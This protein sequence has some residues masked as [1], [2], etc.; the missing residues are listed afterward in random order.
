MAPERSP[1]HWGRRVQTH[2]WVKPQR[3]LV[4]HFC[5]PHFPHAPQRGIFLSLHPSATLSSKGA[6]RPKYRTVLTF[7][8]IVALLVGWQWFWRKEARL[9]REARRV[10]RVDQILPL[11]QKYHCPIS[12]M[13]RRDTAEAYVTAINLDLHPLYSRTV[14]LVWYAD[15]SGNVKEVQMDTDFQFFPNSPRDYLP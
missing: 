9:I 2:R 11:A 5:K 6:V 14:T 3:L 1:L 15:Q 13:G 12:R 8:V 4:G 7:A 10:S